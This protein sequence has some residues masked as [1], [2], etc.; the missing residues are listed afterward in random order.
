MHELSLILATFTTPESIGTNPASMLYMF[1]LLAA[2]TVI[3][4]ATKMRVIFWKRFAIES[5]VLFAT[6][7]GVMIA[8]IIVLNLITW[9]ITS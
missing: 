2:I 9:L 8:A 3:Y 7:S 6:V 1:P 5:L 4:K